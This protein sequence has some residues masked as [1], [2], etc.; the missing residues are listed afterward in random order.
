MNAEQATQDLISVFREIVA[1]VEAKPLT[2]KDHYGDYMSAITTVIK[3]LGVEH[4]KMRCVQVGILL[5][6]AGANRN[7]V[8]SALEVMGAFDA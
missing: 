8:R 2:S 1:T 5:T 3:H 6:Q 4:T 7:G